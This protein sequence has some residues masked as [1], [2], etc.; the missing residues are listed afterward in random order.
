MQD[1][2][3]IAHLRHHCHLLGATAYLNSLGGDLNHLAE[4][5]LPRAIGHAY[6]ERLKA[7]LSSQAIYKI[8]RIKVRLALLKEHLSELNLPNVIATKLAD[9]LVAALR[10]QLQEGGDNLR[11]FADEEA[12]IASFIGEL[13]NNTAWQSWLY[14][15]FSPLRHVD[16]DESIVQLLLPRY[17]QL[18]S[19]LQY[20]AA[21][22]QV[23]QL[24]HGLKPEQGKRLFEQW[25]S[26]SLAACF[27]LNTLLKHTQPE[28]LITLLITLLPAVRRTTLQKQATAH[29][30][31]LS[32]QQLLANADAV[33][34]AGASSAAII[35]AAHCV[36]FSH[37]RETIV[38]RL[39]QQSAAADSING[40]D[41]DGRSSDRSE[42]IIH[43]ILQWQQSLPPL[44]DYVEQL[45]AGVMATKAQTPILSHT[46]NIGG[47][48]TLAGTAAIATDSQHSP[49][50][51]EQS[52]RIILCK[53]AGITL[54][55]PVI[56]SMEV[57]RDIPLTILRQAMILSAASA[58]DHK[59]ANHKD[60]L[61]A[62]CHWL[63]YLLPD[64]SGDSAMQQ[65]PAIKEAWLFGLSQ[66]QQRQIQRQQG[67]ET[68]SQWLLMQFARRLTGLQ[69]SS[70]SYLY[71]Q[72]LSRPGYL[73]ISREAIVMQIEPTPLHILL[74]MAGL[75]RW[76]A[77][78][79][80]LDKTLLI[81]V[82]PC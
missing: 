52:P 1:C 39:S 34:I 68:I 71:R 42:K 6:E 27:D 9:L 24:I 14:D 40:A 32:V 58:A 61:W 75:A 79:C 25:S 65:I 26:V 33:N 45:L 48:P 2:I 3:T 47:A 36:F 12:Y 21:D 46:P 20:L 31:L 63:E 11:V 74:Q 82:Q 13:L 17:A 56:V 50:D 70:P 81:E 60:A 51:G 72:F 54:L 55:I 49:D 78:L 67:I 38:G 28:S 18:P 10:D 15:E 66:Q 57:Q 43:S 23:T 80:W 30:E 64:D 44:R 19:I 5:K 35:A 22:R 8:N 76:Q 53:N 37:Y 4:E 62:D 41:S 16:N 69:H 77:P 7:A 29:L 73:K 59:A